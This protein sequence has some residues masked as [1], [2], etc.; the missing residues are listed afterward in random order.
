MKYQSVIGYGKASILTDAEEKRRTLDIIVDH[1]SEQAGEY[2]VKI[3]EGLAIIRVE[4]DRM[5]GKMS[6]G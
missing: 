6:G 4:I 1:Y 2:A 3:V 5:T